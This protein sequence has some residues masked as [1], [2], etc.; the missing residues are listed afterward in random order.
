MSEAIGSL[1]STTVTI[2]AGAAVFGYVNN[3][4][5]LSEL[6]IA[7]DVGDTNNYLE[8]FRVI[9]IYFPSTTQMAFWFYNS[10]NTNLQTF[11]VR[12]LGSAFMNFQHI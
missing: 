6:K 7:N 9:G 1:L 3:Q 8:N 4:V 10:G 5:R 12:V 2:L 11:Q